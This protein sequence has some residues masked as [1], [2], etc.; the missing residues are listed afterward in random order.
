M[1]YVD[2]QPASPYRRRWW[3]ATRAGWTRR[4]G[5][6]WSALGAIALGVIGAPAGVW[7]ADGSLNMDSLWLALGIAGAVAIVGFA[8]WA[9]VVLLWSALR[10][11]REIDAAMVTDHA[12]AIRSLTGERDSARSSLERAQ[13][14]GDVI[15]LLT[16]KI[17]EGE[18]ISAGIPDVLETPGDVW[19]Q[20]DKS[21]NEY[22][23]ACG[24]LLN[25]ERPKQWIRL[26]DSIAMPYDRSVEHPVGVKP[27]EGGETRWFVSGRG[28]RP[29]ERLRRTVVVLREAIDAD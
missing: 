4:F 3:N 12:E 25:Q 28:E 20:L 7:I 16:A 26:R 21:I 17:L 8:V 9:F 10:A 19:E 5:G 6:R 29:R 15:R 1:R 14:P 18:E 11:P 24:L 23:E 27:T 22:I 13:R 2:G